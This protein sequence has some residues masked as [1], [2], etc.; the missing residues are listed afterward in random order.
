MPHTTIL[1]KA[2]FLKKI[3]LF[4]GIEISALFE[5]ADKLSST[6]LERGEVL[7]TKGS[8]GERLYFVLQGCIEIEEEDEKVLCS[9]ENFFG[10][11]SLFSGKVRNYSAQAIEK[12][13]LFTLLKSHFFLILQEYPHVSLTLLQMYNHSG[14]YLK[15]VFF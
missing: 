1:N 6:S 10:E 12:T 7:F 13:E 5:I 15:K 9:A 3:P 14:K 2:L 4:S 8:Q 11:E